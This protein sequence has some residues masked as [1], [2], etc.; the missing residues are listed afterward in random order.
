MLKFMTDAP[1]S[2]PVNLE[3]RLRRIEFELFNQCPRGLNW[4]MMNPDS[5]DPGHAHIFHDLNRRTYS[6]YFESV[7]GWVSDVGTTPK[8]G[9]AI[10][11]T[12]NTINTQRDLLNEQSFGDIDFSKESGFEAL[13]KTSS[14]TDQII[15]V[16]VGSLGAGDGTEQGY[17]F[18]IVNGTLY[19]LSTYSDGASATETTVDITGKATLTSSNIYRAEKLGNAIKYFING[20]VVASITSGFPTGTDP[21]VLCFSIKNTIALNKSLYLGSATVTMKF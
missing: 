8:L 3:D 1:I 5:I 19:A 15:Y 20:G 18:K 4:S 6:T 11:Q 12:S 13:F 7:D 21:I 17:G 14:I 16:G 2:T 10:M 9:G